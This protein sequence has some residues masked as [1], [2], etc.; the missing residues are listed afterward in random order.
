[1][2]FDRALGQDTEVI[3][4][5]NGAALTTITAI[6]SFDMTVNFEKIKE[7]YLNEKT[8]RVDYIFKG[9][10]GKLD[11]HMENR[12]P[13][14]LLQRIIAQAKARTPGSKVNIKTTIVFPNGDRPRVIMRDV[15]FG[16]WPMNVAGRDKYIQMSLDVSCSDIGVL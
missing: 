13:L 5:E 11:L 8:I 3:L 2:A 1:M 15:A 10:D 7:E 12:D 4:V 14:D 6:Q 9:V 16:P